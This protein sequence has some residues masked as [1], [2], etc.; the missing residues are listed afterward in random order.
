VSVCENEFLTIINTILSASDV[1]T[2]AAVEVRFRA[3]TAGY[4]FGRKL[5]R[6]VVFDVWLAKRRCSG[7]A[8]EYLYA[9][10]NPAWKSIAASSDVKPITTC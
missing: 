8:M 7:S 6:R 2:F 1:C 10:R 4:K 3:G 5:I 9:G